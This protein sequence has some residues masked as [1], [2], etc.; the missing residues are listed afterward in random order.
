[1][2]NPRL[3]VISL[4]K[5]HKRQDIDELCLDVFMVLFREQAREIQRLVVETD[6]WPP[7]RARRDVTE[8]ARLLEFSDLVELAVLVEPYKNRS[9]DE[10]AG[11]AEGIRSC[12]ET[13][14]K[15]RMEQIKTN[16]EECRKLDAWFPSRIQVV[17]DGHDLLDGV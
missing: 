6:H 10:L 14:K 3:D 5:I 12:L 16:R 1:M 4:G 7:G 8:W 15:R 11:A 9:E 17:R 13:A 2:W